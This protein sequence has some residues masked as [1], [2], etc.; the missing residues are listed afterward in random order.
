MSVISVTDALAKVREEVAAAGKAKE[1]AD[2]A[3]ASRALAAA[4]ANQAAAEEAARAFEA[5]S[6]KSGIAQAVIDLA[7]V[8]AAAD[9]A[10]TQAET[11]KLRAGLSRILGEATTTEQLGSLLETAATHF[12]ERGQDGA[13]AAVASALSDGVLR[14]SA[15]MVA[16]AASWLD[17]GIGVKEGLALQAISRA[18]DIPMNEM[19]QL[20]AESKKA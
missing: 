17:R 14:R 1:E 4:Q 11:E 20:L 7:F 10:I 6:Q 2:A 13:I 18:F 5:A 15:F 8:V 12:G 3:E 16:M 9:G 19:H